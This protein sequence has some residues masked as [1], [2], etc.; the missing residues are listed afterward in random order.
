MML[1]PHKPFLLQMRAAARACTNPEYR[2]VMLTAADRLDERLSAFIKTMTSAALIDLNGDWAYLY[3][4]YLNL[5]D[6]GD[7]APL[8]GAPEATQFETQRKAA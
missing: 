7:P 6:E 2:A 4:L 5:P 1:N 3:R 8:S